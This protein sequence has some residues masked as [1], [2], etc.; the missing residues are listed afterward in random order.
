MTLQSILEGCGST[1]NKIV[2]K[3][4]A[5]QK[6]FRPNLMEGDPAVEMPDFQQRDY[7]ALSYLLTNISE[8]Y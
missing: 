7:I 1:L 3:E 5:S 6:H 2:E 8:V 4:T